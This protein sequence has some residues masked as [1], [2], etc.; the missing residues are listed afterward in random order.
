MSSILI[1]TRDLV[2]IESLHADLEQRNY[3]CVLVSSAVEAIRLLE[4]LKFNLLIVDVVSIDLDGYSLVDEIRKKGIRAP[5]AALAGRQE[6][7][8]HNSLSLGID[9]F[10]NEPVR[11]QDIDDIVRRWLS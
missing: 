1:I 11:K 6:L 7:D 3:Y 9:A 10:I 8:L 2:G 4:S 5:I